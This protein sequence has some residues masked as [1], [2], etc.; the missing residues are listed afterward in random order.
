[1]VHVEIYV[2]N[3]KIFNIL[4]FDYTN[5]RQDVWL[6]ISATWHMTP[7]ESCRLEVLNASWAGSSRTM[8]PL[9]TRMPHMETG[10]W[11]PLSA[12]RAYSLQFSYEWVQPFYAYI[13]LL[14]LWLH[15]VEL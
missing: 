1:M 3:I 2:L 10:S 4:A 11:M 14:I 12:V 8:L 6:V 9:E 7:S 15:L 5:M 13:T